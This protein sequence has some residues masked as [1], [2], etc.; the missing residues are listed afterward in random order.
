MRKSAILLFITLFS[1]FT[2]CASAPSRSA[3]V[4]L[5]PLTVP[6]DPSDSAIVGTTSGLVAGFHPSSG[7]LSWQGIPYAQS[8]V[9]P[10]RWREPL[11]PLA[12]EGL[13]PAGRPGDNALQFVA[14][15]GRFSGMLSGS[16]DCL[17]L[18]I[19]R[20]EDGKKERPVYVWIHGGANTSGNS[21]QSGDYDGSVLA[22]EK[23]LLVISVNYRLGP[24]GWLLDEDLV[25]A[26]SGGNL[27]LL[28]IICALRWIRDNARAFG[29]DPANV[30]IAGES[31][32]AANVLALL[33]TKEAAGLFQR[34]IAQ[35]PLDLEATREQAQRESHALLLRAILSSGKAR[36][37][38]EAPLIL[39]AMTKREKA[40]FFRSLKAEIFFQ[41]IKPDGLGMFDWPTLIADGRL[42]PSEGMGKFES[43]DYP[44]KVPLIIGSNHDEVGVF[45]FLSG[46]A[47]PGTSF[48]SQALSYGSAHWGAWVEKTAGDIA[49]APGQGPVY[50]YRFDWGSPDADGRSPLPGYFGQI[51]GAFHALDVPFFLGVNPQSGGILTAILFTFFN[52]A[53]RKELT[54][55][56]LSYTGSFALTGIPGG[57]PDIMEWKALEARG[58]GSE[59]SPLRG[60]ILS[61]D[62]S[63]ATVLPLSGPTAAQMLAEIELG[64]PVEERARIQELFPPYLRGLWNWRADKTE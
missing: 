14:V 13:R 57:G 6:R 35:S 16:E 22:R 62:S 2:S 52:E 56:V 55:T 31:A 37:E 59:Q 19:W 34:A 44:V 11:P 45:L 46:K 23:G 64:I 7:I 28:D 1:F 3:P 40:L 29:G 50:L 24:L 58:L 4:K 47:I 48:Y 60:I 18:N 41:G 25:P 26:S 54:K 63:R 36:Y 20:A 49:S 17:S 39:D 10:L 9:G 32:G 15:A 42:L 51:L 12:W 21:Y 53:G 33:L 27:G 30:T 43:G 38:D 5:L 61:G 8:P